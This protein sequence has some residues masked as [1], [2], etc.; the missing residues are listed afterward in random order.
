MLR[1]IESPH[2]RLALHIR[3][4]IALPPVHT[5]LIMCPHTGT[6]ALT[7]GVAGA[8]TAMGVITVTAATAPGMAMEAATGKVAGEIGDTLA[9]GISRPRSR[10]AAA[11]SKQAPRWRGFA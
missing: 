7:F 3:L 1:L 6:A 2:Y 9:T 8:A 11:G 5:A 10:P 4:D